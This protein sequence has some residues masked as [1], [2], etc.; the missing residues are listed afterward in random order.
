MLKIPFIK[1][2]A[3]IF[4]ILALPISLFPP[5]YSYY[6]KQYDLIFS[7]ITY[8][9]GI[10]FGELTVE[11]ILAFLLSIISGYLIQKFNAFRSKNKEN[12][13]SV[14][15][16]DKKFLKNS[17]I[18]S[19]IPEKIIGQAVK[20]LNLTSEDY[21]VIAERG[22]SYMKSGLRTY[23]EWSKQMI[24][25][26]G[27]DIKPFLGEMY[28]YIN[29]NYGNADIIERLKKS[30]NSNTCQK[31]KFIDKTKLPNYVLIGAFHIENGITVF[32]EWSNIM[33]DECGEK[34]KPYLEEIWNKIKQDY[35]KLVP[36]MNDTKILNEYDGCFCTNCLEET[37][38]ESMGSLSTFN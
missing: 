10:L 19:I 12:R 15:K 21:F 38:N 31:P 23:E 32:S 3:I 24:K 1:F 5:F 18:K 8:R 11:Y 4:I 25:D 20:S 22:F 14:L 34:I 30:F 29:V 6:G 27:E 17:S 36:E 33:I 37:T 2:S 13:N 9:R 7:V 26:L 16:I 28:D 35:K